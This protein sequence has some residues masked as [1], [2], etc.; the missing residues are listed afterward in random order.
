MSDFDNDIRL[1]QHERQQVEQILNGRFERAGEGIYARF[2]AWCNG[3][4]KMELKKNA[5]AFAE[6]LKDSG[7][8]LDFWQRKEIAENHFGFAYEWNGSEWKIRKNKRKGE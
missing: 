1:L 6:W 4:G 2:C 8:E 7:I 3:E 5:R